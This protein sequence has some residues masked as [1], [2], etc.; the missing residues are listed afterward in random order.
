MGLAVVNRL[1][2][3]MWAHS[4]T[5]CANPGASCDGVP[6]RP[7]LRWDERPALRT[8]A[9]AHTREQDR[10]HLLDTDRH[11][12]AHGRR[13]D[14]RRRPHADAWAHRRTLACDDGAAEPR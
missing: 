11:P 10:A 12:P 5:L 8:V 14:R 13:P 2:P 1:R 9:R 7:H 6:E 4:A 3:R